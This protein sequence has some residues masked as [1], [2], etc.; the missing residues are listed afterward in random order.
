[1]T[2]TPSRFDPSHPLV[3]RYLRW[4]DAYGEELWSHLDRVPSLAPEAARAVL[5]GFLGQACQ[6]QNTLN[7]ELGRHG[8]LTLPR[9]W[10]LLHLDAAVEQQLNLEDAWEYRRLLE[11]LELLDPARVPA[12]IERGRSSANDEVR[13]TAREWSE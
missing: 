7:I 3:G 9:E 8:L 2:G 11:L 5:R 12:L 6:A 4:L 13:E 10:T 1:M